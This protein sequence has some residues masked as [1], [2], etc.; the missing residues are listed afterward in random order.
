MMRVCH[1]NTCP[2]GVATQDP[3]LRK[4][5]T[6][7]PEHVVNFM[8][9]V[10]M[11]VRELMAHLGY[12]SFDKMV[13]RSE[14]LEMRRA[15]DHWK[16]RN[17][18]LLADPLQ[19]DRPEGREAD[20]PRSRRST[21]SRRRSTRRR[22]FRSAGPP[23]R[24]G[25]PSR[26]RSRSSNGNRVVGTMLGSEVTKTLGRGRACRT[27][28]SASAS[29]ARPGRASVRSSRAASRSSSKGTRTTTSARGSRAARS[30]SSRRP[31]P[32]SSRRRTSSSATSPSTARRP[33]RPTSAASPASASAS[34]TAASRR[35]SR[36]SATTAAST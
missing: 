11:E 36:R 19:A 2:V 13:G 12:R 21:A 4:K 18:R 30:S 10:A 35:S 17:A 23:S 33:A 26:R 3:Q 32:P 16:A 14:R 31:A 5:F 24:T 15:V 28:R 9:F 29:R 25:R 7:D 22:S 34:A 1:L 27:T 6:G 20:L 8:R